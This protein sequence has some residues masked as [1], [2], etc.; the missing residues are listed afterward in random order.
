MTE[1][2]TAT[3]FKRVALAAFKRANATAVDMRIRWHHT[4]RVTFPTGLE[5]WLGEG[6]VSARG[7]G[8]KRIVATW[9]KHGL[10]V[11]PNTV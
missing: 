4:A 9:T 10:M 3:D 6:I 2:R 1:P 11:G 7:Y 5:G 8:S